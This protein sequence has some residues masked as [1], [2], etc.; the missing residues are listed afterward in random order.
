VQRIRAF[1]FL[2][3]ALGALVS[4]PAAASADYWEKQDG[5]WYYW[6]D[7]DQRWYYQDGPNWLVYQNGAWVPWSGNY[8]SY[9][10][11]APPAYYYP[12]RRGGYVVFPYGSVTWGSYGGSVTFPFGRVT[13]R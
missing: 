10:Y 2:S 1:L 5:Y 3:L 8:R 4:L 9:Y 6:S 11:Q 7:S 13:W 12:A